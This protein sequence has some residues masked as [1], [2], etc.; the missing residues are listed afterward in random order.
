MFSDNILSWLNS[1]LD[2]GISE[3]DFWE[4]TL[5]EL[6]R[7]IESKRRISKIKAQEKAIYDYKLADMI[8]RSVARI[9]SDKAEYPK[10]YEVY[11]EIFDKD[12]YQQLEQEYVMN[13]SA[14]R[15]LQFAESF[16]K[17]L[18]NKEAK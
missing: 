10:I 3:Y 6:I 17:R 9:Y 7:L 15:M 11:P 2:E 4:M 16:N 14:E 18:S 8:G 12:E 13:Q 5:A 1:A